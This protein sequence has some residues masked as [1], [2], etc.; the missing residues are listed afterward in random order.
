MPA[1]LIDRLRERG[2]RM[3]PQRRA[4]AE[5]LAGEH[6]HLTAEQAL[7][8]ARRI[9]PEVSQATVYNTLNDLVAMGEVQE[10][11][12]AGR[13]TRYDPNVGSDHHH[14]VCRACGLVLDVHA[15][16][17]AALELSRPDRHGFVVDAVD[18]TFWG[19]CAS[20][21]ERS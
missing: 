16:G 9:V 11:R 2:W 3:T 8:A 18:V 1:P 13:S 10:V 4:V 19:T 7:A 14:L 20:C 5:A 17:A 21:A 6:V 15:A 12:V